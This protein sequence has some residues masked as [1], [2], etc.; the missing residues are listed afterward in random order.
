[1]IPPNVFRGNLPRP[2][3]CGTK[4][5]ESAEI[6]DAIQRK[7]LHAA[8]IP[9]LT[10]GPLEVF[11]P[12]ESRDPVNPINRMDPWTGGIFGGSAKSVN[13]M[14]PTHPVNPPHSIN[15]HESERYRETRVSRDFHEPHEIMNP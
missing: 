2:G 14:N 9:T 8:R 5:A 7:L 4:G 6:S 3:N 15:P 10:G 12:Q 11:G 13:S 1:M